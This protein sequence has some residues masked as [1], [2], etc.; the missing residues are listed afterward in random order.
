MAVNPDLVGGRPTY[1]YFVAWTLSGDLALELPF[2]GVTWSKQIRKG[3]GFTGSVYF[4]NEAQLAEAYSGTMPGR[5]SLYVVRNDVPVWGGFIVSRSYDAATQ[6]LQVNAAGFEAYFYR[7]LIWHNTSYA[8]SVDQYQ[9]VRNVIASM[10]TDFSGAA[11]PSDRATPYPENA[12]IGLTVDSA[13]SGITQDEQTIIGAELETVGDFLERFSDN[14][15]GFEYYIEVGWNLEQDKFTKKLVFRKAPPSQLP[16]G[17]EYVGVRPGLD[18][19]FFEYPGNVVTLSY[20]DTIDEVGTRQWVVGQQPEPV[21]EV[22]QPSARAA[23]Q[24]VPYLGT[25]WPLFEMVESSEHSDVSEQATLD[26][27]AE[28]YGGRA[29]PPAPAWTVTVNGAMNPLVGS[30]SPGEWCRLVVSD[31]FMVQALGSTGSATVYIDKR[32]AEFSVAVPD[33]EQTPETVTL[34]LIDEWN[35]D[36]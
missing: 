3:G 4:E 8:N 33:T 21:G 23:W 17:T 6:Q 31:P 2:S 16:Q 30:Y 13:N 22:E 1:R 32:I 7:R 20:D 10:Q 9:V 35:D 18:S 15:N 11:D 12:D 26:K 29:K 24:N 27:Y 28:T 5:M 19:N 36:A 14:L 34:T 25:N